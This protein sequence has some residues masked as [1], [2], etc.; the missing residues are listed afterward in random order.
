MIRRIPWITFAAI[1]GALLVAASPALREALIY[2][3]EK[4]LAGEFWRMFTGHWVHFSMRH[5]IVDVSAFAIIGLIV[6]AKR[7]PG[8]SCLCIGAPWLISGASLVFSPQ[9]ERYG[10]LSALALAA[11]VFLAVH[12]FREFGISRDLSFAM[13]ALAGI[14]ILFEIASGEAIFVHSSDPAIRVAAVSHVAGAVVGAVWALCG[15]RKDSGLR[16]VSRAGKAGPL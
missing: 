1:A 4:I 5:L 11:F 12:H 7:L 8:F 14:K 15:F 10:G 16:F 9:M 3:R 2:D 13:L 6:E